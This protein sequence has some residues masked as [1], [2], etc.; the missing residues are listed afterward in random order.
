MRLI[1]FALCLCGLFAGGAHADPTAG[2]TVR[3][4][5][6]AGIHKPVPNDRRLEQPYTYQAPSPY[7]AP[8]GLQEKGTHPAIDSVSPVLRQRGS[9]GSLNVTLDIQARPAF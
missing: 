6:P 9:A 7:A 2:P 5:P 1:T 3:L 8:I 4:G